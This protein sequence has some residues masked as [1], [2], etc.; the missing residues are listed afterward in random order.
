MQKLM[1]EATSTLLDAGEKLAATTGG[2]NPFLVP[3]DEADGVDKLETLQTHH[4]EEI[5]QKAVGLLDKYFGEDDD[6]DESLLPDA[7][8]NTFTFGAPMAPPAQAGFA[9]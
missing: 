5:Y 4:N 2:D 3:F 8:A 7:A 9:F 1:L 6:D